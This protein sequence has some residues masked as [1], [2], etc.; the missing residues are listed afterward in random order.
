MGS[1]VQE[2]VAVPTRDVKYGF[3]RG[4]SVLVRPL[5]LWSMVLPAICWLSAFGQTLPQEGSAPRRA[6]LVVN[7]KYQKLDPPA[8]DDSGVAILEDAL[9]L[10]K[11]DVKVHRDLGIDDLGKLLDAFRDTQKPGEVSLFYYSGYI[12]HDQD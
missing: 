9:K 11:F 5:K 1:R 12:L 4:A 3:E 7:S 2:V 10:A 8:V 6:L